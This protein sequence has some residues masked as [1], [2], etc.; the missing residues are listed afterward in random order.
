MM[1]RWTILFY[2]P[3][4]AI[5]VRGW[6]ATSA[7]SMLVPTNGGFAVGGLLVGWLHIRKPGSYWF[8]SVLT[9]FLFSTALFVVSR[10]SVPDSPVALY[11]T[12]VFVNGFC[13]GAAL[14]YTL[15]HLFYLTPPETHFIVSALIASF[16][17]FGGSIAS[18]TAGGI[19]SRTL[20]AS[21]QSGFKGRGLH[22]K[23][24]LIR[25]L[26]GSPSLVNELS[27]VEKKI[28]VDSYVVALQ[29]VFVTGA[30]FAMIMIVVQ[31][32]T[33]WTPP[34][35]EKAEADGVEE[36]VSGRLRSE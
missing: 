33:G 27:G 7:G 15:A 36:E 1:A 20:K 31:V 9:I 22:G 23:G 2:T 5:A 35:E 18:A 12:I 13:T 8:S 29:A 34:T 6:D 19:F 16:R 25:E 32:G 30:A 24:A 17:G 11:M 3:I 10:L 4:Y 26:M 28:A 21:L 14:N